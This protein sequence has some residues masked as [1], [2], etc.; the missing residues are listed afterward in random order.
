MLTFGIVT[1]IHVQD[2]FQPN[3]HDHDRCLM[4]G[5]SQ[6]PEYEVR[7]S[8][9]HTA[10]ASWVVPHSSLKIFN[11]SLATSLSEQ[12]LS[13]TST[14]RKMLSSAKGRCYNYVERRAK[15]RLSVA[16]PPLSS[17]YRCQVCSAS[18][19]VSGIMSMVLRLTCNQAILKTSGWYY[20]TPCMS[21][22]PPKQHGKG[23]VELIRLV[24]VLAS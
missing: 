20:S 7:L 11:E 17:H 19:T 18:R 13:G 21:I 15:E 10:T 24:E 16:S 9:L 12:S 2:W 1:E 5:C 4:A 6:D 23:Q 3:N 22:C 8:A 14:I